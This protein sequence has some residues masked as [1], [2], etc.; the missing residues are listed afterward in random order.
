MYVVKEMKIIERKK[1][2]DELRSLKNKPDIKIITGVRRAGKSML[3]SEYIKTLKRIEEDANIILVDFNRILFDEIKEYKKLNAHIR[4]RFMPNVNNYVF[5]DEV[6]MCE[7]FELA[8]NDL[9]ESKEFDIYITG[10]KASLILLY[11]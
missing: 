2:L 6:Q 8:V 1:Y 7:K 4:E 5:I 3:L 10:S 11:P 9:Y